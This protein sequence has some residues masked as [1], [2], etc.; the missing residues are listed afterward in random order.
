[1][2]WV[3]RYRRGAIGEAYKNDGEGGDLGDMKWARAR[4]A[5]VRSFL[6]RYVSILRMFLSIRVN[7]PSA[8]SWNGI[9]STPEGCCPNSTA[10]WKP[11][12]FRP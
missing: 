7:P 2:G 11:V 4:G 1:M 3:W 9:Q 6:N 8:W 5:S 10:F 12:L